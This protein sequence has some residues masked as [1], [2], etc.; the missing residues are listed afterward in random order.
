MTASKAIE[1]VARQGGE[2]DTLLV[3][4]SGGG[5]AHLAYPAPGLTLDHIGTITAALLRGGAVI[6][7]LNA[8]RKHVEVLKGGGLA[9]LA[10]PARTVA[11]ILSDVLGDPLDVIA[12]GPAAPDPTT[13]ADALKILDHFDLLAT[14]PELTTHLQRGASG[15]L[16]ETLKPGDPVFERVTSILIG[17]NRLAVEAV[18]K[19]AERL[20]FRMEQI[21][22]GVEGEASEAGR[23]LARRAKTLAGAGEAACIVLGG[24]TTVTVTGSG[25]GGRNTEL[26]LAAA[27]EIEGIEKVAIFTFATDGVDG[28]TDAAGGQ[29]SGE[30]AGRIRSAGLDPLARLAEHDSYPALK[31]ADAL[32][33]TGPTG[34]NVNDVAVALV[35][36]PTP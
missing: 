22:H 21:E 36:P 33:Q 15:S 7:E 23:E 10:Y 12:S 8:V 28:P 26:A 2:S 25:R 14:A 19:G 5:S 18:V 30:T 11:L 4:L 31:A 1:R 20:G 17:S 29:V 27:L 3:L 35:Y 16:P 34:T 32:I 24:E 9:K 6:A 13:Y